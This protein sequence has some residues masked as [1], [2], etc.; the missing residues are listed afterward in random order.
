M[1]ACHFRRFGQYPKRR[2]AGA[3][4][5]QQIVGLAGQQRA[6]SRKKRPR[7]RVGRERIVQ[8]YTVA[9]PSGLTLQRQGNQVAEPAR[10]QCVLVGKHP[11]VGGEGNTTASVHSGSQQRIAKP[12]RL[13]AGNGLGK[14]QPNMRAL[15]GARPLQCERDTVCAADV[16]DGA[17]AV[18]PVGVVEVQRQQIAGLVRQHRVQADD[19]APLRVPPGQV[20]VDGCVVQRA[21]HAVRT[22]GAGN[23]PFFAQAGPPFIRANGTVTA[24]LC[25]FAVP[26]QGVNIGAAA[27]QGTKETD[28][29]GGRTGAGDRQWGGLGRRYTLTVVRGCD[30][31]GGGRVQCSR[32]V[33]GHLCRR[34]NGISGLA[35]RRTAQTKRRQLCPQF[36][37]FLFELLYSAL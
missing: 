19:V 11:V 22:F 16:R 29:F 25:L 13:S 23:A 30:R 20:T 27:K 3:Q 21:Q 5:C 37:I 24:L 9:L 14:K 2:T 17:S 26:A 18:L 12:A 8:K 31:I 7:V 32:R 10:G 1:G 28:L 33:R 15:T 35:L 6:H 34:K 36:S 4:C